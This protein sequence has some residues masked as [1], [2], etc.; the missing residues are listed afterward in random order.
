MRKA[1]VYRN[2]SLV[3]ELVEHD[4]KHYTFTYDETWFTDPEKTAVSLTLPK[5]QI[6]Y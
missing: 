4:R 1:K 6:V 2:G 5:A 3:G